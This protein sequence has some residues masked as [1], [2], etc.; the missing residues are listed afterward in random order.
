MP[1]PTDDP[2]RCYWELTVVLLAALAIRGGAMALRSGELAR[3]P[4]GYRA[5]AEQLRTIGRLARSDSGGPAFP[6]AQRPPLYPLLLAAVGSDPLRVA[7][8]HVLVGTATVVGTFLL[9]RRLEMQRSAW[10][11]ALLV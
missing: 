5:V 10:A 8:L 11:A 6:T 2:R 1:S 4:D 7:I 9:A 3:D